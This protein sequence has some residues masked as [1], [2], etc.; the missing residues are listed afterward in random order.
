VTDPYHEDVYAW[1]REQ[2]E[3]VRAGR[4]AELDRAH[5]AEELDDIADGIRSAVRTSLRRIIEHLLYLEHATA[6]QQRA[7][8]MAVAIDHRQRI[9]DRLDDSPSLRRELPALLDRAWPG[10][11]A[12]AAHLLSACDRRDPMRLPEA[13][14]YTLEQILEESWQPESRYEHVEDEWDPLPF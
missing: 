11:R 1:A 7:G 2:A 8:W 3:F 14:P 10:A 6:W 9:A 12:L 4:L 5:L 13:C